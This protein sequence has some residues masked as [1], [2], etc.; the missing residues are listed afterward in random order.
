MNMNI[1][2][3]G[4][5]VPENKPEVVGSGD[6]PEGI[7]EMWGARQSKTPETDVDISSTGQR[8]LAV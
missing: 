6:R 2:G 5:V 4:S 3:L 7:K 8:Y 1:N